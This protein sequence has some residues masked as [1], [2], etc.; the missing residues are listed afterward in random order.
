MFSGCFSLKI[1]KLRIPDAV[2]KGDTAILECHYDLEGGMLYSVK[3]YKSTFEFFRYTPLDVP[4]T[5]QFN[6][7]DLNVNVNMTAS[8]GTYL[9]L[10][11]VTVDTGGIYSCEVSMDAPT[12]DTSLESGQ[13]KVCFCG[14]LWFVFRLRIKSDLS[15]TKKGKEL[16]VAYVISKL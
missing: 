5:K 7:R 6:L 4:Q 3:W 10:D 13:L 15:Q 9:V 12:F 11:D 16:Y 14:T 2:R 1:T 8:N